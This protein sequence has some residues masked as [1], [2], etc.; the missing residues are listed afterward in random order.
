MPLRHG[1]LCCDGD[2]FVLSMHR[3][4]LVVLSRITFRGF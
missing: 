2:E 4:K 3:H 1:T